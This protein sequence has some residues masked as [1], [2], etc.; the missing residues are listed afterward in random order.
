MHVCVYV[1]T[2][3]GV[4]RE[5]I[6]KRDLISVNDYS[7]LPKIRTQINTLARHSSLCL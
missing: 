3:G 2:W 7:D 6:D 5:P 1:A 4:E